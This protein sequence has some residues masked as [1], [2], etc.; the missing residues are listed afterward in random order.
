MKRSYDLG[1][2]CFIKVPLELDNFVAM[3]RGIVRFW[4]EAAVLP[5]RVTAA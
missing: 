3:V 2:T 4:R 5:S 1:A